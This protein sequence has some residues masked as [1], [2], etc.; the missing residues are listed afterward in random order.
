MILYNRPII[1]GIVVG[2]ISGDILGAGL[3]HALKKCIKREIY[4]VGIGGSYM[5]SENMESWYDIKELSSM[6]ILEIFIKL[7]KF[8]NIIRNLTNRFLNL[9]IDIFVGIDFPDFNFILEKRLK[10][11]GIRTIHY[12]SPS[13]W[14]WRKKRI[15]KFKEV[16]DNILLMF[17][18]EKKLYDFFQIPSTFIGHSLADKMP[19]NPNKNHVRKKLGISQDACCLA[20]LPGSRIKEIRMLAKD[21]LVCAELLSYKVPN[22]EVL[23]PIVHSDFLQNL[24]HIKSKSIKI[25]IFD[26][27]FSR[28]VMMA[29]DVSLLASGTATLECMLAKCPMIVAYRMNPLTFM[30][31][32]KLIKIPWISLPNLLAGYGLVE[33]FIQNDCQP[34]KLMNKLLCLLNYDNNTRLNLQ[35]KFLQLHYKIRRKADIQAARAILKLIKLC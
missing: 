26:Y 18:F 27:Q 1:I 20:L 6:G 4:F 7:P 28:D 13:V 3:M 31:I 14:A 24:I 10:N 2:E 8:F 33:E 25:Q 9:K 30:L 29:S 22:L 11:H 34:E 16:T 35:K 23:I 5:K 19:L 15:F 21:F 17:P 12:V 32:K